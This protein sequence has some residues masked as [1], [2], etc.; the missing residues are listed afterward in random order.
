MML[1]P[2]IEAVCIPNNANN[3]AAVE[4]ISLYAD[5]EINQVNAQSIMLS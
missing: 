2:A 5:K 1:L 4:F 3:Y